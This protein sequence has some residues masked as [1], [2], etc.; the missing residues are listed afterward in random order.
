MLTNIPI[1]QIKWGKRKERSVIC[2]ALTDDGRWVDREM[3]AL[4]SCVDDE[5]AGMAFLLDDENQYLAED[6]NWHQLI[7]E[8]SQVPICLRKISKYHDGNK[9]DEQL[10]G[11]SDDIFGLTYQQKQMEA[12]ENIN[13]SDAWD[14]LYR[15]V[16]IISS[17][18]LIIVGIR[19]AAGGIG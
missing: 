15:I 1:P 13:K 4:S 3:P 9:D 8:K 11:V 7:S 19:W 2:E 12:L 5:V 14:K 10:K 16:I 6:G 18:I 17:T